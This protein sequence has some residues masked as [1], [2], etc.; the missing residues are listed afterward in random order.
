MNRKVNNMQLTWKLAWILRIYRIR[1]SIVRF[2]KYDFYKKFLS[3]LTL[4][5]VT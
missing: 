3:D 2:S 4:L 1:N 5:R